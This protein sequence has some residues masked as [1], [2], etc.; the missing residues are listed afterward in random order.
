MQTFYL[1]RHGQ[2]Q[3]TA[4]EPELTPLG[5]QQAEATGLYLKRFP[6]QKIFS[7]PSQRTVQ[8]A[9]HI[10]AHLHVDVELDALL[11]ERA[12]WGDD[13]Q[14]SFPQFLDMWGRSTQDRD[15]V[16]HIGDSSVQAG[17]RLEQIVDLIR[18][19][20]EPLSHVALISHGGVIG[21]FLRNIFGDQKLKSILKE[22]EHHHPGDYRIRE[23]SITIIEFV[24]RVPTLKTLASTEHLEAL[25]LTQ[26]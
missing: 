4:G 20:E 25:K 17:Q 26:L 15:Y 24:E 13:P 3:P 21:D 6:I 19:D 7:S 8:T 12:N 9:D 11:R 18:K 1:I 22:F 16:P 10:A 2:K 23:C 5:H 14:Q